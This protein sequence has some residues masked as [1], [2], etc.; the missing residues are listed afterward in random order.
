MTDQ[1]RIDDFD[2]FLDALR[3]SGRAL[4]LLL[5][6]IEPAGGEGDEV[7]VALATDMAL[8]P[9]LNFRQVAEKGRPRPWEYLL[10]SVLGNPD[11]SMPSR[12]EAESH[13]QGLCLVIAGDGEGDLS[14]CSVF[15]RDGRAL[16]AGE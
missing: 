15:N 12:E 4:R 14:G 13:L 6:F 3:D 7:E 9:E 2:S 1:L 11:G 5:V 10:V 16:P 8:A